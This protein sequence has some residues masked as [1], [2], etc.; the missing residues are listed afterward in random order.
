[1]NIKLISSAIAL[2]LAS[3]VAFSE[4]FKAEV[5]IGYADLDNDS[6]LKA[7]MG[8]LY[9]DSVNTENHPLAE[10][11]FLEEASNVQLVHGIGELGPID[12]NVTSLVVDYYIPDTQFFVGAVILRSSAELGSTK[13]TDTDWGL[14][15]GFSPIENLLLTT[16]YLHEPGYDLNLDAK[17]VNKLTDDTAVNIEA[18]FEKGDDDNTYDLSADYYLN[19]KFSIGANIIKAGETGYGIQ[20]R[21]FLTNELSINAKYLTIDSN[22]SI[23]L[24]AGLRF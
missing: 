7:M 3:T 16:S 20:S 2:S 22:N 23:F 5:G 17:Y 24:D 14:T 21:I 13:I 19:K 11:A 15:A 6:S 18:S 8:T 12:A 9:F 10:S 1:M 4:S